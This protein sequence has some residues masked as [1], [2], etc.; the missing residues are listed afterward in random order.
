LHRNVLLVHGLFDLQ[1]RYLSSVTEINFSSQVVCTRIFNCAV[2]IMRT[3]HL[4]Q[5][6]FVP[7]VGTI[8]TQLT[9]KLVVVSKVI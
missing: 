8:I 4:L 1:Q 5:E 9:G 3:L 2:A 6:V 7:H